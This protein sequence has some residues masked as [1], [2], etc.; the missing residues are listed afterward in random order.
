MSFAVLRTAEP[1]VAFAAG[2]AHNPDAAERVAPMLLPACEPV[3]TATL[4]DAMYSDR[5]MIGV[6][7][8]SIMIGDPRLF[9]AEPDDISSVADQI[10]ELIPTARCVV[11]VMQNV[12]GR[13]W[14]RAVENGRVIREFG[15][16]SE[17]GEVW[18]A[19]GERSEVELPFWSKDRWPE[20]SDEEWETVSVFPF[21]T[22]SFGDAVIGDLAFGAP[23]TRLPQHVDKLPVT[24]FDSDSA[25]AQR[26]ER[27]GE[28]AAIVRHAK[29]KPLDLGAC[30]PPWRHRSSWRWP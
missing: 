2:S 18:I 24:V 17:S 13:V 21:S 10:A 1:A 5:L 16:V 14:L 30:E 29:I 11:G 7:G 19:R 20:L 22:E 27:K 23:L 15:A 9:E 3:G 25:A 8:T 4:G 12:V 26:S 6:Y 28:I